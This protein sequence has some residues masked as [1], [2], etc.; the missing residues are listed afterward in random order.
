MKPRL[1]MEDG[2]WVCDEPGLPFNIV[3]DTPELAYDGMLSVREASNATRD[4]LLEV[5]GMKEPEKRTCH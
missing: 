4:W 3:G 2:K 5:M 1:R